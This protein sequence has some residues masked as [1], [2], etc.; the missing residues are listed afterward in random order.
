M[1][2]MF[3]VYYISMI[4]TGPISAQQI[5]S[6]DGEQQISAQQEQAWQKASEATR[7]MLETKLA[8]VLKGLTEADRNN[9]VEALKAAKISDDPETRAL[10]AQAP[11]IAAVMIQ[12]FNNLR[13]QFND[14]KKENAALVNARPGMGVKQPE[15]PQN[16]SVEEDDDEF[17]K[18]LLAG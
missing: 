5:K 6:K 2:N 13:K 8:P 12:Q 11:E 14:L 3:E 18:G 4:L 9:L 15:K 16:R 1:A 17:M 7:T 10:Q